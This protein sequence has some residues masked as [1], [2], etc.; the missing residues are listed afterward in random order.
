MQA[1]D[2][3]LSSLSEYTDSDDPDLFRK[4]EV[5]ASFHEDASTRVFLKY[6]V[7]ISR[8]NGGR[9]VVRDPTDEREVLVFCL[10][11]YLDLAR[12]PRT[13]EAACKATVEKGLGVYSVPCIAGSTD[14][15]RELEREIAAFVGAEDCIVFPTG[16]AANSASITALCGARDYIVI[17]KQVHASV[18]EGARLSGAKLRTFRHSDPDHLDGVLGAIRNRG[19]RRGILVIAEGVYGLDG[20]VSPVSTLHH[21]CHRH[22]ARLF[23]DD[24]HGTGVLGG[25]GAGTH[26]FF[27]TRCPDILK[28][29]LSKSFGSVGGWIAANRE[30]VSYLRFYCD[31]LV[32]S[33]G[34]TLGAVAAAKA[35]LRI[36][37]GE[38]ARRR[39][40]QEN[41]RY[42]RDSLI[43]IGVPNAAISSSAIVSIRID[44]EPALRDL[45]KEAYDAGLWIEGLPHPAT[46]LGQERI[47]L[48]VRA[49]HTRDDIFDAVRIL[50]RCLGARAML[51]S[52][53]HTIPSTPVSREPDAAG[54]VSLVIR[55]ADAKTLRLPW[56]TIDSFSKIVHAAGFWKDAIGNHKWFTASTQGQFSACLCASILKMDDG[57]P[58]GALGHMHWLPECE[59]LINRLVDDASGWLFANGPRRIIGPAQV[60][61]QVLGAGVST[62][63]RNDLPFLEPS[64]DPRVREVLE[65]KGFKTELRHT[66]RLVSLEGSSIPDDADTLTDITF[67][68]IR[69]EYLTDDT[70]ALANA[71]NHG[72]SRLGYCSRLSADVLIGAAYEM[73][74]LVLPDLWCLAIDGRGDVVGFAGGF[75]D[76]R[77]AFQDIGGAGK[78]SDIDYLRTATDSCTRGFLAWASTSDRPGHSG[79]GRAACA[80]VLRAMKARGFREAWISWELV[81]GGP[82][83]FDHLPTLSTITLD[84]LSRKAG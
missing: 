26:D 74:E 79:A 14:F 59:N 30:V 42:L 17:D 75:P 52:R 35:S 19:H 43:A 22:G 40:L 32:L 63:I 72:I 55:E 4:A 44:D 28:G 36:V 64:L 3:R 76:L 6:L 73:R 46:M 66:Y 5:L 21:V 54:I 20:D 29:S 47:R 2:S 18:L 51:G 45:V 1:I 78:I 15:H 68:P 31:R 7:S 27:G 50:E 61:I 70:R 69:R 84:I 9:A 12:D 10:A 38:P 16:Q 33:V 83:Q 8:H 82:I 49:S 77:V 37:E 24:A 48:R 57:L 60:P 58:V 80:R 25:R 53:K 11:D 71:F 62:S 67:R 34:A 56:A 13:I 65:R 23:V 41:A 81:D 39:R